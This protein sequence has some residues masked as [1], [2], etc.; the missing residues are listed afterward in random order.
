ML[1]RVLNRISSGTEAVVSVD[2]YTGRIIMDIGSAFSRDIYL[3]AHVTAVPYDE[4]IWN[5]YLYNTI[6]SIV[7][8][9]DKFIFKLYFAFPL[10]HYAI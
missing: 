8:Y 9:F 10:G 6:L 7:I 3:A 4:G 1:R 2:S 5:F